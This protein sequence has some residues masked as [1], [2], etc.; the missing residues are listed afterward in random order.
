MATLGQ[1]TGHRRIIDH[2][3]TI[4]NK[5]INFCYI[6]LRDNI[7]YNTNYQVSQ[8]LGYIININQIK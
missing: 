8:S 4:T 2:L 6:I 1:C 5:T 3:D 7:G